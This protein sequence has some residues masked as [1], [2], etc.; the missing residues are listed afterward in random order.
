MNNPRSNI[1]F[2]FGMDLTWGGEFSYLADTPD[3][4]CISPRVRKFIQRNQHQFNHLF[5][6]YQPRDR[7]ALRA[8]NY[9]QAYD[10]FFYTAN[11]IPI[12]AMHQ[13][14]LNLGALGDYDRTKVI[15]FTN[16]II[17]RYGLSWIVED[18]GI[19]SIKN[20][21]LPYPL[22]PVLTHSSLKSCVKAVKQVK[23][24]L[25]TTLCVEF[26]GFTDG[27]NF[28]LGNMHA[29]DFFR[30]MAE[31]S[32]V[33]VTIDIGHIISYQWMLGKRGDEIF[34]DIDKLPFD[35]CF[36]I[37]MSGCSITSRGFIDAH[38]GVLLDEQIDM[39]IFVINRCPNLKAVTYEDPKFDKDGHMIKK[40]IPN[41]LRMKDIVDMV[42]TRE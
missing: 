4:D 41:Y 12:R 16:D 1:S 5:F 29:F 37:H 24:D 25:N 23:R 33:N 7:Q 18:L 36:E 6:A 26:P 30:N 10:D 14:M 3:G 21:V 32:D 15:E 13:T 39:L 40:S 34:N 20:K 22:A 31:E 9:Y 28:Y 42:N 17:E 2:G 38:H 35:R 27:T 8:E 11:E 19:W